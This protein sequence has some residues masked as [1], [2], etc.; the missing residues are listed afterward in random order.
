[1]SDGGP[2]Y[3]I[4]LK[5]CTGVVL[6]RNVIRGFRTGIRTEN[7]M[8]KIIG[9]VVEGNDI[10][11][12]EGPGRETEII[13]SR[14]ANNRIGIK[15]DGGQSIAEQLG[16]RPDTPAD[17]LLD[18]L[19]QLQKLGRTGEERRTLVRSRLSAWIPSTEKAVSIAANLVTLAT[20]PVGKNAIAALRAF[21]RRG[22]P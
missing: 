18:V 13:G 11:I 20:S 9:S 2:P 1:M 17:V 7:T 16:L 21:V 10:G 12:H 19:E 6:T 14:I 4:V 8:A 3:G 15:S 22:Q 5:N